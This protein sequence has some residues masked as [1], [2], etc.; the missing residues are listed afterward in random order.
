M[1]KE[2]DEI[3]SLLRERSLIEEPP[4]DIHFGSFMHGGQGP[5]TPALFLV[6]DLPLSAQ[7]WAEM[8]DGDILHFFF[9]ENSINIAKIEDDKLVLSFCYSSATKNYHQFK[10]S[11]TANAVLNIIVVHVHGGVSLLVKQGINGRYRV[12]FREALDKEALPSVNEFI[13]VLNAKT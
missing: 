7:P 10:A 2:L 5:I 11:L 1:S 13:E 4:M 8:N 6:Y 9:E 3:R 12:T